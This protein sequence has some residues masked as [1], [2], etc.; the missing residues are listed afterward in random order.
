MPKALDL[1]GQK[2]SRL[3]VLSRAPNNKNGQSM[4]NC[5]CDCGNQ[6]IVC[7]SHL[8]NGNTKSCGCYK[9]EL[10]GNRRRIHGQC[11]S[12]LY[13]IWENMKHR[14]LNSKASNYNNYG[15][16]GITIC[17]EWCDSYE[18]FSKWALNNGYDDSLFID[19]IDNNKGYCPD[20]CRWATRLMQNRNQRSNH[21]ITYQNETHTLS[22]WAEI[23]GL[24]RSCLDTR[25]NRRHWS[26]EDALNT[27]RCKRR[28][29]TL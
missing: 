10:I 9:N 29:K 3:Y 1:V 27:P 6:C 22:E 17:N 11:K 20:N 24:S 21:R 18:T 5:L 16:R 13:N 8:L 23:K 28:G 12:R 26:I 4:W 25:I 2:F 19:R 7:G 15:G 14:C